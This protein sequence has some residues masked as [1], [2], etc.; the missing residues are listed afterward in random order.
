MTK[1]KLIEF[2][3]TC[4]Q[5]VYDPDI[6]KICTNI[7]SYTNDECV[8]D[9]SY[10]IDNNSFAAILPYIGGRDDIIK[11]LK[12]SENTMDW[13]FY[14]NGIFRT[15][16]N[17]DYRSFHN[18]YFPE[19]CSS[20]QTIRDMIYSKKNIWKIRMV[21]TG[22]LLFIDTHQEWV[23]D[24]VANFR[25]GNNTN[26][27]EIYISNAQKYIST[28]AAPY[29]EMMFEN[30]GMTFM[31]TNKEFLGLDRDIDSKQLYF[32]SNDTY[33]YN[34][35][36]KCYETF[37]RGTCTSSNLS[38]H[39]ALAI[40][41]FIA[42]ISTR[43]GVTIH[44]MTDSNEACATS[45]PMMLLKEMILSSM[46]PEAV[47]KY[48]CQY[49]THYLYS[50]FAAGCSKLNLRVIKKYIQSGASLE[51]PTKYFEYKGMSPLLHAMKKGDVKLVKY[52]IEHIDDIESQFKYKSKKNVKRIVDQFMSN[53][54]SRNDIINA[55]IK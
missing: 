47:V 5:H 35:D 17:D 42:D 39:V 6:K 30:M 53:N 49:N 11:F 50:Y 19:E 55:L 10:I 34:D 16:L 1:R 24:L 41:R 4:G 33:K 8:I 32:T 37:H 9:L 13:V 26:Y 2:M 45:I 43:P 20:N 27:A 23:Q 21:D 40:D 52:I 46:P 12:V 29:I 44:P 38:R 15:L 51:Y 18:K 54:T 31:P 7:Y 48:N 28:H 36:L 22:K 25:F 3:T 14:D